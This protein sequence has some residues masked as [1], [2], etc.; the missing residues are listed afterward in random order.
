MKYALLLLL[1]TTL[2]ALCMEKEAQKNNIKKVSAPGDISSTIW[3]HQMGKAIDSKNIDEIKRLVIKPI[4][5]QPF[6][7]CISKKLSSTALINYCL[8]S[9]LLYCKDNTTAQIIF[10]AADE[11]NISDNFQMTPLYIA[12]KI[13][14]GSSLIQ[15]LIKKGVDI[16]IHTLSE[17]LSPLHA[18][19][20]S[21]TIDLLVNAKA[22]LE[23]KDYRA[24]TPLLHQAYLYLD[25][26]TPNKNLNYE[27][28]VS[29]I[30]HGSDINA[31]DSHSKNL[32]T[33]V[34]E[35]T[36][37]QLVYDAEI[38]TISKQKL[39]LDWYKFAQQPNL[40]IKSSIIINDTQF[41]YFAAIAS[42][43][44]MALNYLNS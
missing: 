44:C 5:K 37:N 35:V 17:K 23:I 19:H 3:L 14:L 22:N 43:R 10:D 1:L 7:E 39:P 16:N 24:R 13:G 32:K 4:A 6:E 29:L 26:K 15:F 9:K 25:P 2:P 31:I 20:S 11:F 28:M 8:I 38:D 36:F 30:S 12:C 34:G 33:L 42:T 27:C 18:T 21:E 41:P 40:N